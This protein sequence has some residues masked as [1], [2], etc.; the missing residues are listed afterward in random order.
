MQSLQ[1]QRGLSGISILV[2]L[3]V[4]GFLVYVGIKITP[5]YIDH[6]AVKATLDSIK[7]EPLSARKSK[8]E[9]RDMITKRLYV[10][11]IRHVNRDHIN[12][13]RSGKTTTINVKY[14]ERRHIAH[15]ISLIM[16]FEE[17]VE[18]SAN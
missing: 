4:A 6:Y 16:D 9:I 14:A 11:N 2:I 15:N 3:I 18:L 8:R 1:K 12:I 17:T 10:N 13:Q 7:S 5:V